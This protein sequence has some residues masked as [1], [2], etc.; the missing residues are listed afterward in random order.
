MTTLPSSDL[1]LPSAATAPS[2]TVVEF[3]RALAAYDVD[4]AL[5]LVADDL[6]YSNVSL[7]TIYGKDSGST[8][9]SSW[10]PTGRS[11][12]GATPSTGST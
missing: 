8:A 6:V 11:R 7:P 2:D 9:A 10:V 12:C 1:P 5:D 3:L 4:A